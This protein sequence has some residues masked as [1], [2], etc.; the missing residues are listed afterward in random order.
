MNF[1]QFIDDAEAAYEAYQERYKPK[2]VEKAPAGYRR[3]RLSGKRPPLYGWRKS[4]SLMCICAMRY[5][6]L[7]GR[8]VNRGEFARLLAANPKNNAL[9]APELPN[10]PDAGEAAEVVEGEVL[11]PAEESS[12]GFGE[13]FTMEIVNSGE[14][15][16]SVFNFAFPNA[17]IE[18]GSREQLFEKYG[19]DKEHILEKIL[20]R[21]E[22]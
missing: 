12:G 1:S 18:Q 17:Y 7:I 16:C 13:H 8:A 9:A 11:E 4:A 20:K 6:P 15:S 21:I 3:Y 5:F 10:L 19:M 2:P 14:K 22:D